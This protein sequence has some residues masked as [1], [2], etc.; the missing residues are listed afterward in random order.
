LIEQSDLLRIIEPEACYTPQNTEVLIDDTTELNKLLDK[1]EQQL[2]SGSIQQ[3]ELL[4]GLPFYDL[5]NPENISGFNHVI[6]LPQKDASFEVCLLS[7][8]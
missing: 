1:Y 2:G 6:G 8:Y 5:G 3:F 7:Y 4:K